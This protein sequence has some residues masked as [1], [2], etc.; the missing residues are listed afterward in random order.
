MFLSFQTIPLDKMSYETIDALIKDLGFYRQ[1]RFGEELPKD[2]KDGPNP[3]ESGITID[4][5]LSGYNVCEKY[6]VNSD[7]T[8][9]YLCGK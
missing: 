9:E 7:L 1:S 2:Y 6:G 3:P 8:S 5:L 4:D